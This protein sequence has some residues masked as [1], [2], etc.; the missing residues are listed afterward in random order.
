H[1]GECRYDSEHCPASECVLQTLADDNLNIQDTVA[2]N[3]I[4]ESERASHDHKRY[5]ARDY[6][7][8]GSISRKGISPGDS[9]GCH[10]A[11]GGSHNQNPNA[12]PF[13]E[14]SQPAIVD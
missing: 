5:Q 9:G 4:R 2:K 3:R 8:V 7:M 1:S 6:P 14:I 10:E 12:P 13:V 11:D